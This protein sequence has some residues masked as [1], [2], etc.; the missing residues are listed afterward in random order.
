MEEKSEWFSTWF[1]SPYYHILYD[2][3]NDQEAFDFI[4][5]LQKKLNLQAGSKVLDAACGKGRHAKTLF[6]LGFD[7]EAFDLSSAN[8][9]EAKKFEQSGLHF[10]EH[11]LR[12]PL[13]KE[14]HYQVIFNFFTSFG[15]FDQPEEN[16][17]AFHRF[18]QGLDKNGLLILDFFNPVYVMANLV[19]SEIVQKGDIKFQIERFAQN[20]YLY[21]SIQFLDKGKSYHFQEKVEMIQKNDF[22]AY[23]AQAGFQNID[24]RGNYALE[25]FDELTSPRM[26]FFWVK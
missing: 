20:G 10:F 4:S 24:L 14:H 9:E 17:L 6:D 13:A 7:V 23:A 11:D 21:K 15:Y 12:K 16:Q 25:A 1:N 5:N 8:I 19:P 3:R 18:F 26:I 22:L 2:Q